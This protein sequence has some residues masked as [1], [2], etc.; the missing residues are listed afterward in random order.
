M[1]SIPPDLNIVATYP[2]ASLK[3]ARD[4]ALARRWVD[5]VVSSEGQ[6]VLEKWGFKSAA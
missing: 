6:R 3:N 2:I 1:V 4:L 5:L